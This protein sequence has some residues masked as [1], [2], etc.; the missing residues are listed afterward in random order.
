MTFETKDY[1][2]RLH[3]YSPKNLVLK[4][5]VEKTFGNVTFLQS[6]I[7]YKN[8]K[9]EE[10]NFY[11]EG[12]KQYTFGIQPNY[13]PNVQKEEDKIP[14]NIKGYQILYSMT[15]MKTIDEPTQ[16]EFYFMNTLRDIRKQISEKAKTQEVLDILEGTTQMVMRNDP[17]NG[18]K[19][20]FAHPMKED[21]RNKKK[22]IPDASKPQ[23]LYLKL[24]TKRNKYS[25]CVEIDTFFNGPGGRDLNPLDLVEVRG[26][27]IP[28]IFVKGI[29]WGSHGNKPYGASLQLKLYEATYTPFQ[30]R[31]KRRYLEKNKDP[32]FEETVDNF[33]NPENDNDNDDE[34]E[35]K[36]IN[37]LEKLNQ[38]GNEA[39]E[40]TKRDSDE[41]EGEEEN[42]EEG[43]EVPPT[44]KP[45][46]KLKTKP[47]T[48][49]MKSRKVKVIKKK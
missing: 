9:G 11:L 1:F 44:P 29:Y 7:F 21:P 22:K 26:H 43:V 42:E 32:I 19:P 48:K 3:E 20:V 13:G 4:N 24:L 23:K 5:P 6:E 12:P 8:H 18:V 30:S 2:V 31:P 15:G 37:P 27:F 45:K 25:S 49:I 39:N 16:D 14:E 40:D 46:T 17:E 35:T 41:S 38:W 28:N 47:R 34:Y 33:V 36:S 10:C